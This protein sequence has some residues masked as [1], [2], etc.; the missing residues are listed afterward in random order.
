[1][2]TVA[3]RRIPAAAPAGTYTVRFRV[4]SVDGHVVESDFPFTIGARGAH[5]DDYIRTGGSGST[6]SGRRRS[7]D[8]RAVSVE[9]L[10]QWAVGPL[11]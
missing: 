6:G 11:P 3:A 2:V 5:A 4:L 7:G 1:V 9:R 10:D 8:G